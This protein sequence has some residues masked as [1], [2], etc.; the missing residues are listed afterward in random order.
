MKRVLIIGMTENYGGIESVIMNYYRNIDR[1]KVQ[2]DF[3][4]NTDNMAYEEE[5]VSLGGKIIKIA[6]RSKEY[7]KYKKSIKNFFKKSAKQYSAIWV[8][9]CNLTNLDYLKLA[10]K[11]GI[12]HR[13]IHSHNSQN[14]YSK[15]IEIVHNINKL[16]LESYATDFWACSKEAGEWFYNKKIMKRNQIIIIN[17]A[18][19]LE[20]FRHKSGIQESYKKQLKLE[21]K[22]IIGHVGR[23]HIQ[24]NHEFL[25]EIFNEINKKNN[26]VHLLLVGQGEEESKIRN[27]IKS[28]DLEDKVSFLGARNDVA[29]LMQT[30]DVFLFPSIFE[31]LGLVLVEAQAVGMPIITS[32]DVIPNEVRMSENLYFM[33][34]KQVADVWAKKVLE[35]INQD[36]QSDINIKEIRKKGYDIKIEAKKMQEFFEGD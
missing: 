8:N 18:I 28:L 36:N 7:L 35:V 14:M 4:C 31:G 29:E 26:N 3:L 30:M 6:S 5:I 25:I 21:N 17:N 32:K 23:F 1:T 11:Y 22:I 10:K 19:D 2:F 24:K 33:S 20:K 13:I 34:L 12:K 27:K 9:F 15:A 16:F